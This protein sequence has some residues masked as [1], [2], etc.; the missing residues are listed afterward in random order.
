LTVLVNDPQRHTGTPAVLECLCD[1]FDPGH[2]RILVATGTHSF[3]D[4]A[5][6]QF[7]RQITGGH[8]YADFAWHDCRSK[9]LVP[10]GT[11]ETSR[12]RK[13]PEQT[14]ARGEQRL[15]SGET[16]PQTSRQWH[17]DSS[18]TAWLG[19]P[20]LIEN[21]AILAIGSVEPHYFAGF[22]GAHKTCT[23]GCASYGDI[24]SNHSAAMG[25]L[26]QPCKLA[27]NPIHEGIA[28]LVAA[29]EATRATGDARM[30]VWP[31]V[32]PIAVINLVQVQDRVLGAFGGRP[33][34]ALTDAAAVAR[35]AFTRCLAR[36]ADALAL[37]VTG[38]LGASFYQADKGIKN[39]EWAVRDGGTI[40]LKAPCPEGLGQDHFVSLLWQAKTYD[41]AV[42]IVSARGYRL[43]DHKAVRLRYLTDAKYRRVRVF[44]VSD[45]LSHDQAAVLGFTK[46][47]STEDALAQAGV[48]RHKCDL[49]EIP[50]AGNVVV[51]V[52]KKTR[53]R[54]DAEIKES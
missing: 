40:I 23:I 22:T 48:D 41:E 51:T 54:G 12:E 31:V 19:H 11:F 21:G 2:T 53:R 38:P 44:I 16:L 47:A 3:G 9:D 13:R 15:D 33:L 42:E 8:S 14:S 29:L 37:D 1:H 35:Q 24:E 17:P 6:R 18:P 46:A 27:G 25:P 50:D 26:C 32:S 34:E 45:G 30:G 5:R 36:Q 43:G 4:E 28:S 52:Q 49:C 39:N 7:E 10:I 20:W